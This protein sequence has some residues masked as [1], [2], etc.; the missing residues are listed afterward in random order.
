MIVLL[1]SESLHWFL[2][3]R[4]IIFYLSHTYKNLSKPLWPKKIVGF[5][6]KKAEKLSWLVVSEL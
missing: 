4:L 5:T 1:N 6:N 2:A 3:S